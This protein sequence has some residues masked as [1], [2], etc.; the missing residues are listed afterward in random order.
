MRKFLLLLV[1]IISFI[2]CSKSTDIDKI[3]SNKWQD[4]NDKSNCKINFANAMGF[5]WDIM[6]Y[7][8]G[9]YSLEEINKDLGFDFK[10]FTEIG[11]RVIFLKN[12]NV[13]YHKEWFYDVDEQTKG[14]VFLTDLTKFKLKKAEAVFQIKKEGSIFYLTSPAPS[15]YPA[16]D[17]K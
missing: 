15:P 5:D 4:C 11:D 12:G 1:V 10:E 17:G 8:S 9:K 7:F 14:I 13:V 16:G 3:V 2:S 6:Y